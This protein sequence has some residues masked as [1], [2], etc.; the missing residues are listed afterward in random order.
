MLKLKIYLLFFCRMD[1]IVKVV[2][3][4][5]E[6]DRLLDIEQKYNKLSEQCSNATS[7]P[8][9]TNQTGS[10]Y[11]HCERNKSIPLSQIVTENTDLHAVQ[12]PIAGILP[13]ITVPPENMA[14][15]TTSHKKDSQ[16]KLPK[17]GPY[18]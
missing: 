6:Y 18:I 15:A 4:Q 7:E 10:G 11:C 13:S 8:K 1:F 12:P 5:K 3:D 16:Q 2:I 17:K 14:D 9:H